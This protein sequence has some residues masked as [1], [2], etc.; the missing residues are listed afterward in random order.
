MTLT[1]QEVSRI[2]TII[3][4]A[5]EEDLDVSLG[6]LRV[7]V[8]SWR[9]E[10][11]VATSSMP[12][13]EVT[14]TPADKTPAS[15]PLLHEIRARQLGY[16]RVAPGLQ[17]GSHVRNGELIGTISGPA[18]ATEAVEAPQA[19]RL[20]DLCLRDGDFVEYAQ[21]LAMLSTFIDEADDSDKIMT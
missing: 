9:Q 5:R 12:S 17:V 11:Q 1:Y 18:N 20:V 19:G 10:A 4:T 3:D 16:F 6:G 14:A 13:G 8:T 21:T 7:A 15:P 2:L